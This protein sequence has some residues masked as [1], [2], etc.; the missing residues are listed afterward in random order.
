MNWTK[1]GTNAAV[2]QNFTFYI[3]LCVAVNNLLFVIVD[4]SPNEIS[5]V[6]KQ[7]IF[8]LF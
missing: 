7:H 4:I 5:L 3:L 1:N 6:Y 8:Y 2:Y